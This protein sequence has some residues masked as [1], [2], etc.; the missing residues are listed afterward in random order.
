MYMSIMLRLCDLVNVSC[1]VC[2]RAE[3]FKG[4]EG[5]KKKIYRRKLSREKTFANFVDFRPSAKV[6]SVNF[7]GVTHIMGHEYRSTKVFSAKSNFFDNV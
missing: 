4:C 5:I 2:E 6:F 1:I 3:R 7:W